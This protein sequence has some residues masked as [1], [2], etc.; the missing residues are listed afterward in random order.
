MP[1]SPSSPRWLKMSVRLVLIVALLG[2]VAWGG[3]WVWKQISPGLFG[4]N[5]EEK[6][7]TAKVK[8]ATIAEEIVSVG[9]IRAVFSTELRAEING[10]IAKL[11]AT[12]GQ[13]VKKDAEILKLDQT[14]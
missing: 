3:R 4:K 9:R 7:V 8:T 11:I 13:L 6:V 12:D 14:D 1:A 10:R 5:R 2:G